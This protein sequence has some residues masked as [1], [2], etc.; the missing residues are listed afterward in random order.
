MVG[1][2]GFRNLARHRTIS[3][4][5]ISPS[6]HS[7]TQLATALLSIAE[8][9]IMPMKHLH[10]LVPQFRKLPLITHIPCTVKGINKANT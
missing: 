1:T 6:T 5:I 2:G 9:E 10:L 7:D 8:E 3:L 4:I